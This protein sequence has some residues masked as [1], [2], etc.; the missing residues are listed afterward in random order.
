MNTQANGFF[1]LALNATSHQ[2]EAIVLDLKFG[3]NSWKVVKGHWKGEEEVSY[4]IDDNGAKQCIE[5]IKLLALHYEQEAFM[6]IRNGYAY[7][8][9]SPDY[10]HA[11]PL[12]YWEEISPEV[13]KDL[14]SYTKDPSTG[15]YWAVF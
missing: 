8:Y 15:K 9:E 12:G 2:L 10:D 1:I 14:D 6:H 11:H 7:L 13:A 3:R 5:D 4:V